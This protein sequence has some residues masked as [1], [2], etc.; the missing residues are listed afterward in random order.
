MIS[1]ISFQISQ[2]PI[3]SLWPSDVIWR[4]GSRSTLVQV[5]ACCLMAT[6]H[7][8]N[9]CW[10]MISEMWHSPDS[11]FI[12]NTWD[13]YRWNEFEI[14][15]SE[16]VVKS[17][18]GQGVNYLSSSR[19]L[20][21]HTRGMEEPGLLAGKLVTENS[22]IIC[23]VVYKVLKTWQIQQVIDNIEAIQHHYLFLLS[24]L[25]LNKM[26]TISQTIFSDTFS[27]M[28]SFVFWLKFHRCLFLRV[29]STITQHW[30]RKWLGAE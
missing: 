10:L 26:A 29:L 14:Y 7:Y 23:T 4:Q 27:W 22:L 30:F 11:N 25:P 5:M 8:L 21:T 13:I 16:T 18:R 3:N 12:E 19:Q 24:H 17:P 9:Q 15:Q 2:G 6:S 1:K 20:S 28:E